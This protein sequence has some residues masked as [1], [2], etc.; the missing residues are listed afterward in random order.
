MADGFSV[1]EQGID[2]VAQRL[3]GLPRQEVML[4][5]LYFFLF[6]TLNEDL[7]RVLAEHGLNTTTMLALTMIYSRP[8]NKII[9]S[10]LSLA[11]VSSRTHI[12]RLAD[13]LVK[14]GWVDR[15]AC[16][17]DRRKVFLSL[18]E[19]GRQLVEKVLPAQWRYVTELW[20]CFTQEEKALFEALLHRLL[21]RTTK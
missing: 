9:P 10:D 7:N 15:R 1:F 13:D 18:T 21:A 3:P 14:N 12:T 20:S 19:K 2:R 6:G 4:T 17:A 5:R 11:I 8:D 16:S